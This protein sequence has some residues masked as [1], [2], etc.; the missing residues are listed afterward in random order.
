MS[1]EVLRCKAQRRAA[2]EEVITSYKMRSCTAG[3]LPALFFC[4]QQVYTT[5]ALAQ[6]ASVKEP[7]L[8]LSMSTDAEHCTCL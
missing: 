8:N 5:C 3:K 1:D 2:K 6:G 7:A 4:M